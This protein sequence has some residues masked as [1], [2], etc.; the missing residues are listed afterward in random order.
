MDDIVLFNECSIEDV[1]VIGKKAAFISELFSK[2]FNIPEG[3]II[4]GNLFVKFVEMAKLKERI[5]E[6]I[7]SST[8]TEKKSILAQQAIM[9]TPFP[10]DMANFIYQS[11]LKLGNNTELFV[12]LRVSSTSDYIEDTFL[13]NIQGKE[14]LINGIKSCWA[15][16]FSPENINLKRFKPSVIV[17]RMINPMKSGYAYSR[18]PMNGSSDE[19]MIQV[20]SGLGNSITLNQMIP[21]AYVVKKNTLDIARKFLKEQTIKYELSLEKRRTEKIE[22]DEPVRN[23]LEDYI[24][25]EITKTAM[26]AE[27]RI[28]DPI[29]ISFAI[30]KNIYIVSAKSI[31]QKEFHKKYA[32][33]YIEQ[34]KEEPQVNE[35]N[36]QEDEGNLFINNQEQA[37]TQ[38]QMVH[39]QNN[40]HES[41]DSMNQ[42]ISQQP[43]LGDYDQHEQTQSIKQNNI[44]QNQTPQ[45]DTDDEMLK[46]YTPDVHHEN[47]E[48][49]Q[50]E[51]RQQFQASQDF[52]SQ[53][54]P[55]EQEQTNMEQSETMKGDTENVRE[56]Q[57]KN[58]ISDGFVQEDPKKILSKAVYNGGLCIVGCDQAVTSALKK[59]Y[60]SVFFKE[61]PTAQDILINELKN[62]INIPYEEEIRQIRKLR[63]NFINIMKEPTP[64][65]IRFSLDYTKLFIDEF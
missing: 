58:N 25:Q 39:S 47:E 49:N 2:G 53:K 33:S 12:A 8:E 22:L 7:M 55:Q 31:N 48:Q 63:E 11:Y 40:E 61:P 18:N 15:S 9:N 23:I 60:K 17:Q 13:L 45:E 24:M 37:E 6:I 50:V 35:L 28:N 16:V 27:N 57:E 51:N 5:A 41:H 26:R 56:E 59:K 62:R 36:S 44:E 19:A 54:E 30:D 20:C 3:F 10:E 64:V 14:R 38:N 52:V 29:R 1:R 32:D 46:Y 21:S 4:T 43:N 34:R 65:E 42:Q